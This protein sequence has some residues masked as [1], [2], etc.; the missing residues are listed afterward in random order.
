MTA[1]TCVADVPV[2]AAGERA[3]LLAR[4]EELETRCRR[5]GQCVST[6]NAWMAAIDAE[7]I[8]T[9]DYCRREIVPRT[10]DFHAALAALQPG[11]L[12]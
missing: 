11:D 4:I 2:P 8:T 3:R 5:L 12:T 6:Y 7:P 10:R 1:P 9:D